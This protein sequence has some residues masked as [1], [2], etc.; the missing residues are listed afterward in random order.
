MKTASAR[1]ALSDRIRYSEILDPKF[2]TNSLRICL[3][4]PLS[5]ETSAACALAGDL[6]TSSSKA[7]PTNAVMN[8]KLHLLYGADLSCS[9]SKQGDLQR[10]TLNASAIADR[11]A[12]EQEPVFETL[13]EILLGCILEPNLKDGGYDPAE[14]H[15]K[16]EEL[17]ASI[18]AEINEKRQYAIQQ[19]AKTAYQGEPAALSRFG[20]R[21]EAEALTPESTYQAFQQLLRTARVEIFFVG[22]EPRQDVPE[23]LKAA[24][25]AFETSDA[26]PELSF[27]TP[28]PAKPEPATIREALPVNQCKMVLAWK[29]TCTEYY[30][31]KLAV[32]ILGGTPSSK[33]FANVREKMS[34]CYYC[35]A[36]YFDTKQTMLVDC[37]IETENIEK[38]KAA[39]LDQL[40][41]LQ[42]GEISEEELE[43]AWMTVH[44]SMQS[45][46]DTPSSYVNWY[47]GQLCRGTQLTPQEEEQAYRSVTKAQIAAAA[48]SM[49]LD[50]IYR[51][52]CKA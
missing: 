15:I 10:I 4:Q 5:A 49:Q 36:S 18:D 6:I 50:T 52:E 35:A 40:K 33:L 30:A 46:G 31:V 16:Q 45:I 39:I 7:Y 1:M 34:L 41:A 11:Y 38:T 47:L 2:K 24:F 51:M 25:D 23:R 17:L 32:L 27:C 14:F 26:V 29:T 22:P 21:E 19:T 28:S 42:A 9:V 37:G 44:N 13:L 3:F 12:L 8:Q 43:S 20:T 48:A